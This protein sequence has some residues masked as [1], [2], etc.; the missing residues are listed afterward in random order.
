MYPRPV[1]QLSVTVASRDTIRFPPRSPVGER[2][3]RP[4]A[5]D[6]SSLLC[7]SQWPLCWRSPGI[8]SKCQIRHINS[9]GQLTLKLHLVGQWQ[10]FPSDA[11]TQA[12]AACPQAPLTLT[13]LPA[14]SFIREARICQQH[15]RS[16][17]ACDYNWL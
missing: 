17:L 5:C 4:W 16:G 3:L 1:P 7:G 8:T 12:A 9:Q 10:A 11:S 15:L 6:F 14:A 2:I 13:Q